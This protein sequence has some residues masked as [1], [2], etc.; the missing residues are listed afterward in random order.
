MKKICLL[1]SIVMA[2]SCLPALAAEG[3]ALLGITDE[4]RQ[5][6]S[7]CFAMGDTLVLSEYGAMNTYR[8]GESDLTAYEFDVP[9]IEADAD[10]GYEISTL[11]FAMD[12][13]LYAINLIT[14]YG[15]HV[16][17]YG[18]NVV[19]VTLQSD[20]TAAFTAE[21]VEVDWSDM[22][23]QY[24]GDVYPIVP[25]SIVGAGGKAVL[26]Y[27]GED[28]SYSLAALDVATGKLE[29]IDELED[30]YSI[31]AYGQDAV[32][33]EQ[34]GYISESEPAVLSVYEPATGSVR[35][36][37]E[38]AVEEFSPL[39]GLAYDPETDTVYCVKGGEV[40]VVD[41]NAGEVGQAVTDM[42]IE[43]GGP[44]AGCV[45]EGGYYAYAAEGAVVR[46][47]DLSQQAQSRLKIND[48]SWNDSVTNAFYH[49]S[50]AHGDVS[51]VLS[52]E[53]SEIE[54]L[55]ESM[56][57]QDSSVDVYVLS[58]STQAYESLHDRGYLMELDGSEKV[59]ALAERMYPSVREDLSANGHLVAVPVSFT[60]WTVGVNEKALEALGFKLEDVPD[61]WPDFLDFLEQLNRARD[62]DSS[63]YMFY[64]GCTV[65]E[66]KADLFYAILDDFQRYASFIEPGALYDSEMMR[67]LLEKLDSMDFEAMGCIPDEDYD[68]ESLDMFSYGS[69]M[70]AIQT[71]V[72]CSIGAFYGEYTP[73]LMHMAADVPTVLALDTMVVVVNPFTKN[74]EAALAFV[75]EVV[76]NLS[77][78]VLYS[79]DESL[80]E[81]VRG[82]LNQQT[83]NESKEELAELLKLYESASA[84]DKQ[85]LQAE[86]EYKQQEVEDLDATLWDVSPTEIEWV[87]AHDDDIRIA[88]YNWLYDGS[89]DSDSAGE[90]ADLI[91][92]YREGQI[93]AVEMLQGIDKKIQMM[94]MEGN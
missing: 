82:E 53:Y 27:Y 49:F 78:Q 28:G 43:T 15:E 38:I 70:V 23:M 32:L 37:A 91:D 86:V 12:G 68:D 58:T 52:R 73:I 45:L 59:R 10:G 18:G 71:A 93:S 77:T 62:E 31:T 85:S 19:E 42:P 69:E 90:A 29:T 64:N 2:L 60:S 16:G 65:S 84:A 36:L 56:M 3:D 8:V 55:V 80:S 41:M 13:G 57:N 34:Y 22:L 54:K 11:P 75:D 74:P 1:L 35:A 51:V 88:A 83:L 7:Y 67:T 81:A 5:Y 66:A 48:T 89:G 17:F 20:G 76:D 33:V 46:N 50:N 6:F 63:V 94:L 30:A 21:A 25:E 79:L 61:N 4:E 87:R 24:E 9:E 39:Q 14:E 47:L 26:R 92:Q 40:C 44:V 72:G